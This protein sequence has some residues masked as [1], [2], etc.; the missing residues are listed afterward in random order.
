MG[1]LRIQFT[2]QNKAICTGIDISASQLAYAENMSRKEGIKIDLLEGDL[3]NLTMIDDEMFDIA[4]SLFALD[5]MQDLSAAFREVYRILKPNGIFV[6][7]IQH[8]FYNLL[9]AEDI[10][11]EAIKITETILTGLSPLKRSRGLV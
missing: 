1:V 8:P 3:E 2:L 6:F 4:I 10:N 7:S 9:G 11:L 5:W